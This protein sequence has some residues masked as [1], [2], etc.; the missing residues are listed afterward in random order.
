MNTAQLVRANSK[1]TG[2]AT[3]VDPQSLAA[4]GFRGFFSIADKWGLGERENLVLL[5]EPGRAT[6]YNWKKGE[7]GKVS[8]D[9][10][11]RLSHIVGIYK[12]LQILIPDKGLAD[13]WVKQENDAPI[14]AGHSPLQLMLNGQLADLYRVRAYLDSNRGGWG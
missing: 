1:P 7:V 2:G 4:A 12:A 13:A 9:T 3:P 6:Y 8:R 14:F 10:L 5:G 11:E